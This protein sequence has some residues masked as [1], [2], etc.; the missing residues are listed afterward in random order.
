MPQLSELPQWFT[1]ISGIAGALN[2]HRAEYAEMRS[3]AG[4]ASI[5]VEQTWHGHDLEAWCI[6]TDCWQV[7][8]HFGMFTVNTF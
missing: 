1:L 3:K 5:E 7:R 6:A 2:M 4:E 8:I